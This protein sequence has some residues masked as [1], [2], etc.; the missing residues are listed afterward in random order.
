MSK[1]FFNTCN[2]EGVGLQLEEENAISQEKAIL[3]I[4]KQFSEYSFRTYDIENIL[5][6][7]LVEFNHDS[8]KR[9]IT[10][11]TDQKLLI[12][13]I[14]AECPGIYGKRVHVWQFNKAA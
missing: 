5:K 2:V 6:T 10:C 1:H 3:T 7:H 11:L 9:A 13:S 8:V 12:K 14:K 4:F